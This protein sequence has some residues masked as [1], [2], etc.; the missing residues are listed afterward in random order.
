MWKMWTLPTGRFEG[1]RAVTK[2]ERLL[3]VALW[4]LLVS[5]VAGAF[6]HASGGNAWRAMFNGV[7]AGAFASAL[8]WFH[9]DRKDG[10]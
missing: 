10:R 1:K 2:G 8:F 6:D 7:A 5:A 9:M 4:M 3:L